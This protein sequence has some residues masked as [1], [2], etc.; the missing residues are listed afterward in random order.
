MRSAVDISQPHRSGQGQGQ[1]QG[2]ESASRR[3]KS[4]FTTPD[5]GDRDVYSTESQSTPQAEA[6]ALS[7]WLAGVSFR[8]L[9]F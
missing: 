8:F 7:V 2:Q 5:H 4:M 3:R 9:V 1:G 6:P